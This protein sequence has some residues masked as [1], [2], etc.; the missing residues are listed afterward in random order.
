ML[1]CDD[2]LPFAPR[3]ALVAGVTGV[4][5]STLARRLS[6]LWDLPY[7]ELDA[8][9]HGPGWTVR[10]EFEDDVAALATGDRWVTEWQ[11]W[12]LGMREVLGERAEVCVWLNLPRALA[13]PRLLRRTV[14]RAVTRR[15]LWNGNVEPP[16]WTYFTR[17]E[18]SILRWEAKTHAQWRERMPAVARDLPGLTV[19]E[20]RSPREVRRWLAGPASHLPG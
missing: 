2:P 16:L 15:V 19:V 7:A 8:L 5:K 12:H 10:E 4:G 9:H 18:E 3:R 14:H 17:P 13:L 11:Y 6:T 1:G 20:L